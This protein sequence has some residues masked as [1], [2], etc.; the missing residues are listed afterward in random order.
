MTERGKIL[1]IVYVDVIILTEDDTHGI[2]ELKTFLH[3]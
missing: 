1:L 2:E 3:G